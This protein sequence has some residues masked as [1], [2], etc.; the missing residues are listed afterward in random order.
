MEGFTFD[1]DIEQ[2]DDDLLA[3]CINDP[4]P[5]NYPGFEIVAGSHADLSS[6]ELLDYLSDAPR[7]GAD[8]RKDSVVE[9]SSRSSASHTSSK[10]KVLRVPASI[11]SV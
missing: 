7:T 2:D 3:H 10:E 5:D 11:F 9:V 1:G 8:V 6:P 4:V